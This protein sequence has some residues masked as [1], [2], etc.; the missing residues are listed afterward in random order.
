MTMNI[1]RLTSI[2]KKFSG[3]SE[4]A[5]RDFNLEVSKGEIVAL[6]GESGCGKTT[7]LRMI[8]G[9]ETPTQGFIILNGEMVVG[10]G[11]FVSPRDRQIGIVFQDYALFPH[12]TVWE[13]ITFGLFRLSSSMARQKAKEIIHL[14][15][16]TGLEKRYPHQLSGGQKQRVALARAM[17]PEPRVIL[18]DEPFSN[19]DSMLKNQMRDDIRDIVHATGATAIFVT[20]DTKD[21]LTIADKVAVIRKGDLLQTGTPEMVYKAPA[22]AYVAHFFGKTNVVRAIRTAQGFQTPLGLIKAEDLPVTD[23]QEVFLSI[24]PEQFNL[25]QQEVGCLCGNVVQERFLGEHK[26][27]TCRVEFEHGEF[28]EIVI[29]A[30]PDYQCMD[31]KCYFEPRGGQIHIMGEDH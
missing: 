30:S 21:V 7:I 25:L 6:L 2:G 24:R 12:K 4:W 10:E 13:N 16:L 5:V 28:A 27:L 8:A 29:H 15:S 31:Q 11:V 17:A 3:S 14:C 1:L 20:H 19:L 9:F 22:N 18:F 26:E 23:N